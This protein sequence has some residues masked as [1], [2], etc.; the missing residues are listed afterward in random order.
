MRTVTIDLPWTSRIRL[1]F[2][3]DEHV[4]HI[5]CQEGL[6]KDCIGAVMADD[7]AYII[8]LGDA[9]DAINMQDKRFNPGELAPWMSVADLV[10][11]A[12]AET[13]R[14][15]DIVR[16]AK[17][18]ILARLSGNHEDTLSRIFERDVYG[19]IND[20][21]D[22]PQERRLG[23]DGFVRLRIGDTRGET[24]QHPN[25]SRRGGSR[26]AWTVTCYVHHGYAGGRLAG[27]KA[28]AL[29]RL[30]AAF[31]ADIYAM[32]H[33]HTKVTMPGMV[34]TADGPQQLAMVNSGSFLK[35]YAEGSETYA[36]RKGYYPQDL[37]PVEVWLYPEE[38][39]MRM[40][41]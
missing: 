3:G 20:A 8:G 6:L 1:V 15:A 34:V 27:A 29:G 10:D 19:S 39:K 9:I 37:G 33:S 18:R 30:P 32:G 11:I 28:L 14:Y 2:L 26:Q 25:R 21:L 16:P 23:I 7:A 35:A 40:I 4:G 31:R 41:A 17:D 24:Y 13:Q 38:R 12:K 5:A 22:I 36:E